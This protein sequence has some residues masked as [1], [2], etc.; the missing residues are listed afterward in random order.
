MAKPRTIVKD[1]GAN[2]IKAQLEK[3]ETGAY[4][5]VGFPAEKTEARTDSQSNV[6]IAIYH[7]FG[8]RNIPQRSF[9]RSTYDE[10]LEENNQ[11]IKKLHS[12]VLDQKMTIE[13]ALNILGLRVQSQI[14]AKIRSNIPPPVQRNGG[15]A[16]AL[17]DTG[18]MINAITHQV[19]VGD[20]DPNK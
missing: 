4:V 11:F 3:I 8:T 13:Q 9:L 20:G 16:T 19:K 14:R 17:I 2:Y 7:E 15:N 12:K 1:R 6:M 18:Q 10:K 5:K